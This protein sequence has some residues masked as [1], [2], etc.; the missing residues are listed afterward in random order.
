MKLWQKMAAVLVAVALV[1]LLFAAWQIATRSADRLTESIKSYH[2]ATAD[3]ALAEV[4]S[5]M[6][7][8]HNDA[9][10]LAALLA[11]RDTPAAMREAELRRRLPT[12]TTVAAL[13]VHA[14]DGTPVLSLGGDAAAG[15]VDRQ[16][17]ARLGQE[18]RVLGDVSRLGDSVS[19]PLTV[20]LASSGD[21]MGFLR[22]L[23]DLTPLERFVSQLSVRHFGAGEEH[24]RLMDGRFL[25]IA[26][27]PATAERP[28]DFGALPALEEV[29]AEKAP[30]SRDLAWAVDYVGPDGEAR[31]GAI[32]P[33]PELGWAAL[34]EES[35]AVAYAPVAATWDTAFVV[36]GI[37]ILIAVI[38][39][40]FAGRRAVRPVVAIA[41]SASRVAA[42]DFDV[43][44]PVPLTRRQDELAGA[45]TSFNRMA[46]AL[47]DYRARLVEETRAREN[48]SRFLAPEVVERVV[49]G[50]LGLRL[51]GEEAEV[52][53][54]FADVVGFTQL[55]EHHPPEV[56]V[57]FL[58]E[59]FTIISEIVFQHGGI[60][61][62]FIGDCA[63]ALWGAPEP[64]PDGAVRAA[65]AALRI[66]DWLETAN[67]RW[68]KKF[69]RPIALGMAI[70][71]GRAVIGNVGSER[72][73]DY[74]AIGDS[75]N[76]AARLERIAAPGQI[77]VTAETRALLEER[78]EM[79]LIGEHTMVGRESVI[80][81]HALLDERV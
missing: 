3:V 44:I 34:V 36:G 27:P 12:F 81:V 65:E 74:T 29:R 43:R 75:V 33:I 19:V 53:V 61:D 30:F 62:K 60:I 73:M 20:P 11:D 46:E 6:A 22:I 21:N 79:Q 69:G 4:R 41:D 2:L 49:E 16:T 72:R 57:G 37:A 23:V 78:F 24:I 54:L 13:S 38:I 48:L 56:V 66:R 10:G 71:T 58:N 45:A 47:T 9:L 55:A 76:V 14:L 18:A 64:A 28:D 8:A 7:R 26:G 63:M 5:L 35:Q 59:L 1:P 51:G 40:L 42:G 67:P 17:L 70:H 77:L 31:V 52:T 15:A 50:E 80:H 32:V 39:G 25:R 68:Q